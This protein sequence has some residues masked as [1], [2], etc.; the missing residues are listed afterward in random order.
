MAAIIDSNAQSRRPHA[1]VRDDDALGSTEDLDRPPDGIPHAVIGFVYL[2]TVI[3]AAI[4]LV[5]IS[6]HASQHPGALLLVLVAVPA[7][8]TLIGLV[9]KHWRKPGPH[10][11]R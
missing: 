4:L 1:P 5:A 3:L 7:V 2:G 9:A 10:S 6:G 8:I 11:S